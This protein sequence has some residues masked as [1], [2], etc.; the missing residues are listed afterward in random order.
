MSMRRKGGLL[1]T[2]VAAATVCTVAI[3]RSQT[4][5]PIWD[6]SQL[7]ETK[8]S[9]KQY[10]LTPRGDV[11]GLILADGTEVKLPPHLTAQVVFA[12][13]PGDNVTVRGLRSRALPLVQAAAVT[14]DASGATVVDR[15]PPDGPARAAADQTFSGKI[16]AVL[17][18]ARGEANGALLFD[19]TILRLPPPEL[20]STQAFLQPGLM[21]FVRGVLLES[22]LGRVI[23]VRAIGPAADRLTE[24]QLPPPRGPKKGPR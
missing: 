20:D 16:V 17:H 9:V 6:T 3:A 5:G 12:I 23:D 4:P 21:V 13:K 11:D 14:N 18:G 19:G 7:P 8:G 1:A 2:V 15:G 10:S 24:L 22:A